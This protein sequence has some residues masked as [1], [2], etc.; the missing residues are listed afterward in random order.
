[1]RHEGSD[2]PITQLRDPHELPEPLRLRV[3][4]FRRH[5]KGFA[6]LMASLDRVNA[7]A[8]ALVSKACKARAAMEDAHEDA[9]QAFQAYLH[10][11]DEKCH[12]WQ[13]HAL[14]LAA[15]AAGLNPS[16]GEARQ[17]SPVEFAMF[18]APK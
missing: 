3:E 18:G 8:V 9:R 14:S 15:S 1:M 2:E 13:T 16:T 6:E 12:L 10:T 7:Q 4:V 11:E 5:L 17:M